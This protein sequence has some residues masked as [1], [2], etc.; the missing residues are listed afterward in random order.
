MKAPFFSCLLITALFIGQ[1]CSR[2][3]DDTNAQNSQVQVQTV[4]SGT[5]RVTLFTEHGKDE[6]NNFAGYSFQFM[7][8]GTVSATKS[9]ITKNGAWSISANSNKYNIDLGAKTDSNKP[10]GELTDDWRII[11]ISTTE[12]KLTDDNSS[13][14]EFLTFKKN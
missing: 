3:S 12:I 5:W 11:S 7:P 6:T 8:S 9:G 1:S 2:G 10:I 4:T 14:A 13:S